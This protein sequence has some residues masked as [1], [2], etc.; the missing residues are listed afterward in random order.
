MTSEKLTP[1]TLPGFPRPTSSPE[2]ADGLTPSNSPNGR[3]KKKSGRARAPASPSASP[4]IG[5]GQ[6]MLDTYGPPGSASSVTV[7]LNMCLASRLEARFSTAGSTMYRQTWRLRTTPSGLPYWEHTASV[8]RTSDKGPGSWPTPVARED[9]KSPTAHLAMKKRM[10]GNRT[11]ITSL[12]VM[13]KAG[14]VSPQAMGREAR[15]CA[16][17]A[18]RHG[19]AIEPAGGRLGYASIQSQGRHGKQPSSGPQ[20]PP[21]GPGNGMGNPNPARPQGRSDH[22]GEHPHQWPAW[23]SSTYIQ[24]ADGKA[25]VVEPSIQPLAHGVPGRVGRLRGY[26][27]AIVPQVAAAFIEESLIA[28]QEAQ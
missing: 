6:A 3:K 16:T 5:P 15:Q 19:S 10:G 1:M 9:N 22:P 24:C 27:N 18:A 23:A 20:V 4:A 28:L 11:A 14:W 13:A 21:G 12:Q 25:R 26:G 17:P 7:A 2:S 8:P